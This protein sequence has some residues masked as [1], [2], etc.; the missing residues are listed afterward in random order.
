MDVRQRRTAIVAG[1]VVLGLLSVVA[2]AL[3]ALSDDDSDR[4]TTPSASASATQQ[5]PLPS[6]SPSPSSSPSPKPAEIEDGKHFVYVT[7]AARLQDGS[8]TITFDLA[9]FLTDGEGEQ[10]AAEHGDEFVNGYYIQNDNPKL[11]TVPLADDVVVR[12]IPVDAPDA[13]ELQRG[14]LDA[15]LESILETNQTDYPGTTVPWWITV[16]EGEI[17]RIAQQYLP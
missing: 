7:D 11:R 1:A 10:A 15:W 8:A 5:Q 3:I 2:G 16:R 9:Y 13:T 14:N 4:A 17:V 12:Y 6:E